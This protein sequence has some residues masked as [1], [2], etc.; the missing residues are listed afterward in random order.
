MLLRR[1]A[2]RDDRLKATA[3]FRGDVNDNPCSHAES[4]DQFANRP[5]E[6]HD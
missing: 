5:K 6:S 1:A 3:I 2:V 4:F